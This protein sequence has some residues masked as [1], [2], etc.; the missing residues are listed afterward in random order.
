MIHESDPPSFGEV[1]NSNVAT[2]M[3][4]M[5]GVLK[6]GNDMLHVVD[7]RRL[8]VLSARTTVGPLFRGLVKKKLIII[9]IY[10]P[11]R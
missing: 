8:P 1:R 10:V 11:N 2:G 6:V 5:S 4:R 3:V 9:I 7:D